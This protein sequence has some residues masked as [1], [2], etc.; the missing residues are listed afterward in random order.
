MGMFDAINKRLNNDLDGKQTQIENA[1]D[2]T[3]DEKKLAAYIKNKV[4]EI[5]TNG[6]RVAREGVIMTNI[7]YLLGYDN[8]VY[9]TNT[10]QYKTISNAGR[11]GMG[12]KRLHANK[13]LPTIQNRLARLCKNPPKYD[14]R[15][16][17]MSAD[18]KEASRLGLE[19]LNNVWDKQKINVKRLS[20]MMWVQEAGYSFM[21]VCWDD[22]IGKFL[23]QDEQGE[24]VYEGDVRVDVV[25]ALEVYVDPLAKSM[26]D[27]QYLIHAKVRKLDYFRSHYERGHLVKEE[28]AWLLGTQYE[29]RLNNLSSQN[30]VS[31][32]NDMGA[33]KGAAI[34]LA[35]YERRS[36]KHPNGRLCVVANGVLLEDKSLPVGEMPFVKFDDVIVGGSFHSESL[37]THLRPIQDQYN[38]LIQKRADWTN[39][40]LAG[41]YIAPKGHG[42]HSQALTNSSGEVVEYEPQPNAAPPQAMQIPVIPQ[43]AYVEEEKLIAMFNDISGIQEISRGTLP[44]AGIPAIGMQFLQE[45][46][47]TRIGVVT[48]QHEQAWAE[49]G[50]LVLKYVGEY[51]KTPRVLKVAGE[52]MGY[53]VKSFMGSDLKDNY[54]VIVVRGSTIPNSKTLKRQE[55]LNAYSQ[56]LLGDPSDPKLRQKVLDMLEF[57]DLAEAWR[58]TSLDMAQIHKTISQIE[59]EEV[60]LVSELDNHELHIQEK[61]RYRKSEKFD[62]LS[63]ASKSMLLQD[64][65]AHLKMAMNLADPGLKHQK[66]MA[67][68]EQVAGSEM[69]QDEFE[70]QAV[71]TDMAMQSA[72]PPMEGPVQ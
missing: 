17:S 57:G 53:A 32:A 22:K 1:S 72:Q 33:M 5:R 3:E 29:N 15:P 38:R 64:I 49:V 71:E 6:A 58:D 14:I 26:D 40:M 2:Q 48:E 59:G 65:E 66:A 55:I 52:G 39:L 27:A 45:Q 10:R 54:D 21:K 67:E 68:Q 60:P 50:Q 37:I 13:I 43:Y 34:E 28:S 46:D 18:D 4:E 63:D 9:D 36:S 31:G 25:N 35:Y 20:L 7:A 16:E 19:I 56:G 44:S 12:R 41:K 61:N 8:V 24:L 47:E 51:Y 69:T 70:Q 30:P 23:G 11:G 62:E 42:M